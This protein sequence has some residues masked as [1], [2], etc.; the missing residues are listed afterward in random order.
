MSVEQVQEI[1]GR[2]YAASIARHDRWLVHLGNRLAYERAMLGAAGGIAADRT[3]PEKG[4]A[5]RSWAGPR[6][7]WSYIQKVNKA[8]VTLLDNGGNGG[9]NF[10]RNIPFDKLTALMAAGQVAEAKASGRL[11]DTSD[12]TGFFLMDAPPP[13]TTRE[14]EA[15]NPARE[16]TEAALRAGVVVA[17]VPQL[18]PTPPDVAAEVVAA[19]GIGEGDEVLEPSAGTGNLL[20]ALPTGVRAF[21]V[22]IDGRLCDAL[23]REFAVPDD[24]AAGLCRNV[25]QGDFLEMGPGELGM[26]DRVVMNPPFSGGADIKHILHARGFLKPGGRLAAICAGGPRQAEALKR[27]AS[28]WRELPSGTFASEGT[29]VRTVLL[30]MEA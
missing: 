25:L 11:V 2:V 30:T 26:Y 23:A 19:A 29:G 15:V 17:T 22:E 7:G 5:C 28:S 27:F 24:A 8:S 13:V 18:F 21:A 9:R 20:R 6:G 10:T 4:G 3:K 16:A 1:A 14:P 12:G